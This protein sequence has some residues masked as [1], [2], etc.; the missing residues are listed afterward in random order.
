M[1]GVNE[2]DLD[3]VPMIGRRQFVRTTGYALGAALLAQ[4]TAR[5]QGLFSPSAQASETIT[6]P[7]IPPI[8]IRLTP[9]VAWDFDPSGNLYSLDRVNNLLTKYA[10]DR[11]LWQWGG[12]GVRDRRKLN[13]P[14]SMATDAQGRVY[15]TDLGNSRVLVLT[16]SKGQLVNVIRPTK[17]MRL[18]SP[19]DLAV[20]NGRIYVA[21]TLSH[22]VDIYSLKGRHVSSFGNLGHRYTDL[23]GPSSIAVG[24]DTDIFV[25]DK[26]N[27][28]IKVFNHLGDLLD[29]YDGTR[30]DG[31]PNFNPAYIAMSPN[32]LLY[33]ADSIGGRVVV[34]TQRGLVLDVIKITLADGSIAQPR[35]LGI[36]ANDSLIV[37][38]YSALPT[39][40]DEIG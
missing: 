20:A 3:E 36:A 34:M 10:G 5:A 1:E 9:S 29:V 27:F 17:R 21:D 12:P 6:N 4:T 15:V 33:A 25:V 38:A 11:I 19:Q 32:G 37:S 39:V 26:G 22:Q 7:G 8:E 2:L 24:E 23:N 18:N 35:H 31:I 16:K 30:L 14:S 28:G 40:L 13:L